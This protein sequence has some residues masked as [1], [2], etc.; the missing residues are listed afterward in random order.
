MHLVR[1]ALGNAS[2]TALPFSSTVPRGA[3]EILNNISANEQT[4]AR[5]RSTG[6]LASAVLLT[7]CVFLQAGCSTAGVIATPRILSFGN[8]DLGSTSTAQTVTLKNISNSAINI[9][10]IAIT[11]PNAGD[12]SISSKTCGSSMA[13]SSSCNIELVFAPTA[14]GARSGALTITHVGFASPQTVSLSGTGTG[15][16]STLAVTPSAL[17]FPAMNVGSSSAPETITLQSSGTTVI[18]ISSISVTGTNSSDFAVSSQTCGSTLTGSASCTISVIFTPSGSG[19]RAAS[20]TISDSASG[21]P[22]HVALSGT[23]AVPVNGNLT[24]SPSSLSFATTAVGLVSKAQPVAISNGSI[25]AITFAGIAIAGT[26]SG[27]FLIASQTCG[28][29]LAPAASCSVNVAFK[30]SVAGARTAVLTLTDS[31]GNSPQTVSLSGTGSAGSTLTIAPQNPTV[32]VNGTLQF[33]ATSDVTWSASCGTIDSKSGFFRA[34]ST[35]GSC[36]VTATEIGGGA[37]ASTVVT[38]TNNPS[39]GTLAIYPT[40]AA[41][42]A[43][44][45]QAFQAQ[46][47][48][49]P[50]ANS[51][52]YSVDG[53]AGGN[54]TTGTITNAGMYTAPI[55]DGKHTVTGIDNALGITATATATVYSQVSVDFASRAT[56][57]RAIPTDLFGAERMDS[58]HNAADLALVEAG[59]ISYARFYAQ[60]PAVFATSTPNWSS[61]DTVIQRMSA[62]G[63]KVMLQMFQTPPWLQPNPNPCGSAVLDVLPTD[64]TSWGKMAAQY[65]KHMDETF[66]GVVTDYEIWNEPNTAALCDPSGSKMTD[67]LALYAAAAPLMRAQVKADGSSARIGGPATAGLQSAWV[68]AML[69]DATISQN[70]DF[71]S[72]HDYMFSNKQLG[73]LWDTYNGTMSVYQRT[74]NTGAG[75]LSVYQ[76]AA[77][78]VAAGKQPQGKDLPIYNSEYNLNW[79]YAKTCCQNDPTYSPVWNSMYIADVL[80]AIYVGAPNVI[81]HMVY[82]AANAH[83]YF[84]LIGE[85]NAD[86][87]CLYPLGSVPQAYPS[88]FPHQL[89][90]ATN[91]LGLQNG[92]YMAQSISPR[93]MGNGLVVTGFYTANLD[94]IVLVNP[95]SEPL[96]NVPVSA[97][98]TG[99]SSANATLYQIVNGQ[100]IQSSTLS[101]QP[102]GGTSYSTTVSLG[103][104]SVQA[105]SIHK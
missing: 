30:P 50:D 75:P 71:I 35:P 10:S 17:T 22:H 70:I 44:A 104:Y 2:A 29:S 62:G 83:P 54:A 92:G 11:G 91:Y 89:F 56:T 100:S 15:M 59:G 14:N 20:L 84:C 99:I 53:V 6:T 60:I 77:N 24:V 69:S 39:S 94:A 103:P 78:L 52:S 48:G 32:V 73:A 23:G 98:N 40:T 80:N 97:T 34:P 33:S 102:Q 49:V 16:I 43:G 8:V 25:A 74:Q 12:F 38:V 55:A 28:S 65:V 95:G 85:I 76:R 57:L 7:L 13:G 42:F 9:S 18:S 5:E 101:L 72:Y 41:V 105:I 81:S 21:S 46:L 47:S 61:I 27:D 26:N 87:D 1:N 96:N 31:A 66:P 90:G 58:V 67:Y 79:D 19:S 86:M 36:T 63:V 37:T 68:N 93:T 4:D 51:L 64:F 82:F 45:T 88:Y 3:L